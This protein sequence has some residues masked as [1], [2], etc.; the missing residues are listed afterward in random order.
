MHTAAVLAVE[1]GPS[2]LIP[3]LSELIV[4]TIAFVLLFVF[5]SRKVFPIFE[6]VYA[7]RREAIA[8]G[9]ERAEAAQAE[10]QAA[11][12]EYREQLAQARSEASRIR[13]DAQ[14]ERK[15]IVDEARAEAQAAAAQVTERAQAHMHAELA[16]ART[17]LSR[18]VGRIAVDLAN[19]IVGEN[20][21]DTDR[22]RATVERFIAD[23]ES[24]SAVDGGAGSPDGAA[25]PTGSRAAATAPESGR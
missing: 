1:G 23:L 8:G 11:L 18:D 20:L 19:R 5:L 2:P 3:H 13:T 14:A 4:G 9:M 7:E 25:G 10:A 15:A 16:Q 12:E 21:S 17:E 22:T 6:R 24:V